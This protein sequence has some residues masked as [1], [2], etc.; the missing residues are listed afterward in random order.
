MECDDSNN[1]DNEQR[2]ENQEKIVRII[3]ILKDDKIKLQ[4][5][6]NKSLMKSIKKFFELVS[7]YK[8]PDT[9]EESKSNLV[10]TVN[11]LRKNIK[12]FAKSKEIIALK[13]ILKILL[14]ILGKEDFTNYITYSKMNKRTNKIKKKRLST[15]ILPQASHFIL[16][17]INLLNVDKCKLENFK[18]QIESKQLKKPKQKNFK[19]YYKKVEVTMLNQEQLEN[20]LD[21]L[22]K[23]IQV[24]SECIQKPSTIW[25]AKINKILLAEEQKEN[26]NFYETFKIFFESNSGLTL[27]SFMTSENNLFYFS[28]GQEQTAIK[29]EFISEENLFKSYGLPNLGNSCYINCILQVLVHCL[30]M[31]KNSKEIT[32]SNR[33]AQLLLLMINKKEN[34]K[35]K[36]IL[37]YYK[38]FYESL[39]S[40]DT[41]FIKGK[42]D[43]SKSLL[44]YLLRFIEK[45]KCTQ[46]YFLWSKK[47]HF[48]H[49]NC[50]N[51]YPSQSCP[52]F[53]ADF[54]A[55]ELHATIRSIYETFINKKTKVKQFCS[56]CTTMIEGLEVITELFEAQY[57][58]IVSNKG[59]NNLLFN[60]VEKIIGIDYSLILNNVVARYDCQSINHNVA[61]C[62]EGNRWY[63]YNDESVS[64]YKS[65][66]IENAYML[67]YEVIKR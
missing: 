64:I 4:T 57:F 21:G 46:N 54:Q 2:S 35:K 20:I 38:K 30:D 14:D 11:E 65:E 3:S 19:L 67:F 28:K 18:N 44:V 55:T 26:L 58:T 31:K 33:L 37:N 13:G 9:L 32:S 16:K 5:Q 45:P 34:E 23:K 27:T 41:N 17:N 63:F 60:E 7:E 8:V 12:S 15:K 42:Q 49:E 10:D 61:I 52:Y 59:G 39:F 29:I 53:L 56:H 36:K 1:L 50:N 47:I 25:V 62:K 40:R 24:R 66:I 43:D 51:D 48:T 6:K 22:L